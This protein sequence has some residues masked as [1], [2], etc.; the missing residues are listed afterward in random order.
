[1]LKVVGEKFRDLKAVKEIGVMSTISR[2]SIKT[3]HFLQHSLNV[4]IHIAMHCFTAE[5][6]LGEASSS[7]KPPF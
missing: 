5:P 2:W 1:M 6:P 3:E 7:L 4:L